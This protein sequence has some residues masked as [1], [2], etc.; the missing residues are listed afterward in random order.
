MAYSRYCSFLQ[1]PFIPRPM[2]S[3]SHQHKLLLALPPSTNCPDAFKNM[4]QSTINLPSLISDVVPH[5]LSFCDA[6]TLSRASCVCRSW[7]IMANADELWTELC[8]EIF[9]VSPSELQP[10]PDPTRILYIMSH[11]K[12]RETLSLGS[13]NVTPRWGGGR[14]NFIQVISAAEFRRF[15]VA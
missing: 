15:S 13:A 7:S 6:R 2:P 10:P 1:A 8:K 14:N 12:L 3:S 9:G 4:Y 11:M 5:I